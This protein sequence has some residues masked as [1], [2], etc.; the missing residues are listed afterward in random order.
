MCDRAVIADLVRIAEF[1]LTRGMTC[2]QRREIEQVLDRARSAMAGRPDD[3]EV[4]RRECRD[5]GITIRDDSVSLRD[6]AH[7]I[8]I[9]Y[10]HIRRLPIGERMGRGSRARVELREVVSHRRGELSSTV[11]TFNSRDI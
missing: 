10:S 7:L 2:D 4:L 11:S 3:I 9:S 1:A 5:Q 8:G 6:A